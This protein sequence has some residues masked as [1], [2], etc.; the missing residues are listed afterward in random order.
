[1][2][3]RFKCAFT[4]GLNEE[5]RRVADRLA[6]SVGQPRGRV[7]RAGLLAL[8][9]MD[10]E[11]ARAY[12]ARARDGRVPEEAAAVRWRRLILDVLPEEGDG[13]G[14][15]VAQITAALNGNRAF[16]STLPALV[17]DGVVVRERD[18][19]PG[20]GRGRPCRYWRSA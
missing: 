6:R 1:M 10:T 3:S 7:L 2:S 4:I 11:R 5:E 17:A 16:E 13:D 8:V 12:V 9:D 18:E 20:V 19:G 14:M 15:T